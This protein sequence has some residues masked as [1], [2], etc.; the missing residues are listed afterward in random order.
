MDNLNAIMKQLHSVMD[1][2]VDELEPAPFQPEDEAEWEW[3][4]V[5]FD[6][7][8]K[9]NSEWLA[10]TSEYIRSATSFEI[11]CWEDELEWK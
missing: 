2:Q 7:T 9:D 6:G 5:S 11:Q 4:T 8:Q 3:E 10:L 1:T